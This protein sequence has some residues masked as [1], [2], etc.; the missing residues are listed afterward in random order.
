LPRIGGTRLSHRLVHFWLG[1]H[2]GHQICWRKLIC[3]IKLLLLCNNSLTSIDNTQLSLYTWVIKEK[4]AY[5]HYHH[6]QYSIVFL[7]SGSLLSDLKL[8]LESLDKLGGWKGSSNNEGPDQIC[9]AFLSSSDH[10]SPSPGSWRPDVLTRSIRAF[11]R[12]ADASA[13]LPSNPLSKRG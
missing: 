7:H 9:T 3:S 1:H 12:W 4:W 13:P 8:W 10:R 11:V 5:S 2:L 6:I